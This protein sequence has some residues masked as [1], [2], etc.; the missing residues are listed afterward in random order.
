MKASLFILAL[1]L[2]GMVLSVASCILRPVT[3]VAGQANRIFEKTV[4]EA[5]AYALVGLPS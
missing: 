3:H 5:F 4:D 1:L 2:L